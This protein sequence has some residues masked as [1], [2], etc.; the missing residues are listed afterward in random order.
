MRFGPDILRQ[1]DILATFSE[2]APRI[3]RTYLSPQHR[4]AGDYLLTLMREAGMSASF[5][6]LGN[7]VGRYAATQPDAAVVMTGSHQDSVRNAGRY[8][9]LFGILSAIACVRDLHRRGVRLP[10][11]IEVVA[12]GD[13]E[14]VRF[15][16]TLIGSRAMTGQ[17]DP[18]WLDRTDESGLSLRDALVAFGGDPEGWRALDRRHAAHGNV[19]AF[20]E[21]H[22][23][24]GPVLLDAG[25]AV[26]VVTAIAGATRQRVRVTGLAG[27][28]GTVPMGA[29]QDAL[30]AAAEMVLAIERHCTE[31]EGLVGTVGRLA[32]RPGAINVIAQD[33]DFTIDLRSGDDRRRHDA[34]AAIDDAIRRI[35]ARRRVSVAI[36][37]LYDE[38]AARCD[39]ELQQQVAAAIEANGIAPRYLASGA[40]HDAMAFPAIMPMA[41]LFVRC[42][43]RGISHHPDEIISAEDAEVA[44]LVLLHFFE[45]FQ[46]PTRAIAAAHATQ[47]TDTP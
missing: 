7:I 47:P 34:V 19:V 10:I 17:F 27:H 32:V 42:G 41:M 31:H 9:G 33:V 46:S 6:A 40:G 8:D 39:A 3:T 15:P 38:A 13:E 2:D 20:I 25:L 29:R 12:F 23:E 21:S 16:A 43:N 5:D 26:G 36:E 30:A 45:H 37:T 11:T 28:A 18:D 4:A 24:Q 44:T 1:A 14:G 35:G 22:I